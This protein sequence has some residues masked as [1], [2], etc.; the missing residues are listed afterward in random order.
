MKRILVVE[1][2]EDNRQ[3]GGHLRPPCPEGG[4]TVGFAGHP[5]DQ[6][7]NEHQSQGGQSARPRSAAEAAVHRQ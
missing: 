2:Q 3:T 5:A 6:V 7:R 4:E 1:D